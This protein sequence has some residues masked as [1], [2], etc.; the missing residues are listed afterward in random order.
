MILSA[1][2]GAASLYLTRISG[3]GNGPEKCAACA[4]IWKPVGLDPNWPGSW[5]FLFLFRDK[6][7]RRKLAH[8]IVQGVADTQPVSIKR[9]CVR[10][11]SV[12]AEVVTR[13]VALKI[14]QVRYSV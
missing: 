6:L 4:V 12:P 10:F 13:K 5:R 11:L 3:G 14:K 8:S 2:P 1:A 7:L 9:T